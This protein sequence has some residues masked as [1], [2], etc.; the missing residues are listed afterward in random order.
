MAGEDR[1]IVPANLRCT[2]P[3]TVETKIFGRLTA[4][5]NDA[6][7]RILFAARRTC[8]RRTLNHSRHA[9]HGARTRLNSFTGLTIAVLANAGVAFAEP[10]T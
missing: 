3:E 6:D 2:R 7:V 1:A 4:S 9:H 8:E 5:C 10:E